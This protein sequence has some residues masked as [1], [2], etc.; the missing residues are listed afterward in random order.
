MTSNELRGEIGMKPVDDPKAD[1][2]M[3]SNLNM[4]E[5]Q[6]A[7][8]YGGQGGSGEEANSPVGGLLQS[9]GNQSITGGESNA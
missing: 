5:E 2:L 9:L 4:T 1:R 6:I 8:V 7:D 3:N